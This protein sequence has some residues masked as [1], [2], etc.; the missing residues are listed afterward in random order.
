VF[1]GKSKRDRYLQP[2]E[3]EAL[4]RVAKKD[5]DAYAFFRTMGA[6]GIRGVEAERLKTSDIDVDRRGIWA[7]TAKRK[8]HPTRFI[9]LDVDS[10][11]VLRSSV[12]GRCG[13]AGPVFFWIK[14]P[15]TRRRMKTL[16]KSYAKAA[17]IRPA[18]SVHS[19]RHFHG[20]A[21]AD[22]GMMPQEVAAR[23]GHKNINTVM[24][25]FTLRDDRNREL[26]DRLGKSMFGKVRN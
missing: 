26:S 5:A 10:L 11:K 15:L 9:A 18:L 16:F 20:T 12:N 13:A 17:G 2:K 25:Y 6:S 24:E 19:L 4:L 8:D 22:A 21:C 3:F 14:K 23:L 7:W 1:K